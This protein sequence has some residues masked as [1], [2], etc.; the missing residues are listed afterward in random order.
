MKNTPQKTLHNNDTL[1]HVQRSK[2]I[3][4]KLDTI[5]DPTTNQDPT[6]L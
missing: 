1:N 3:L 2:I 6:L 4:D 5:E